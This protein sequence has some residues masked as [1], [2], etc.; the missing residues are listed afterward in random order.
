MEQEQERE[1]EQE[2]E[3]EME[4]EQ[5][6]EMEREQERKMEQQQEQE[7]EQDQ[8]RDK[9]DVPSVHVNEIGPPTIK[10]CS[11]LDLEIDGGNAGVSPWLVKDGDLPK[12]NF[13]LEQNISLNE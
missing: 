2:Q 3:R 9:V 7:M 1:M 6:R 12:D 4:Q 8:E 13:Q 5:E 11:A 10:R